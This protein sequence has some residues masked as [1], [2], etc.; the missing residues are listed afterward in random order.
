MFLFSSNMSNFP[1]ILQKWNEGKQKEKVNNMVLFDKPTYD[2]L[3]SEV[4]KFKLITPSILS[5]CLRALGLAYPQLGMLTA[6]IKPKENTSATVTES[7]FLRGQRMNRETDRE[8]KA[9]CLA[10]DNEL[11]PVPIADVKSL[12]QYGELYDGNTRFF[13]STLFVAAVRSCMMKRLC[14]MVWIG[15]HQSWKADVVHLHSGDSIG[16][17]FE[18]M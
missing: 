3:L 7:A 2:K 16:S 18:N 13:R 1:Y 6:A 11:G 8:L 5:D 12:T 14:F 10:F 17:D 9:Y 15:C 4:P